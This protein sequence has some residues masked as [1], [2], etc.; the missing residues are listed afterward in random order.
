MPTRCQA[1]DCTSRSVFNTPGETRAFC[2]RHATPGMVDVK[3]THCKADD[4]TSQP[5]FNTPGET[6]GAFCKSH[7]APGMINVINFLRARCQ[8]EGCQTWPSFN[9]PGETRG[10]FCKR[11]AAPGMINVVSPCCH[12]D[13]C[14]R[15]QPAFG[16]PGHRATHCS[17]H[18]KAGMIRKPRVRCGDPGCRDWSTHGRT[19]P[20][21]CEAHALTTDTNLIERECAS[22]GLPMIVSASGHCEF[23]DPGTA[24][25]RRRLSFVREFHV[26]IKE[27]DVPVHAYDAINDA[28]VRDCAVCLAHGATGFVELR[29]GHKFHENCIRPWLA[30]SDVCPICRQ[31]V[32]AVVKHE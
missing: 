20:V 4:C 10:A 19:G 15:T 2:K 9:T 12:A 22:C 26:R 18:K 24:I 11:H 3:H 5:S 25:K 13:G 1:D 17:D 30:R 31:S 16:L 23:C 7:A 6:R 14:P 8:A 29:C 28:I 27:N 32:H 21:R